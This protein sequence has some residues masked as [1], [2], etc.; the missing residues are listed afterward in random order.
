MSTQTSDAISATALEHRLRQQQ[1]VARFGQ[2]ALTD[3]P[4]RTLLDAAAQVVAEGLPADCSAV[5][6]RIAGRS[7]LRVAASVGWPEALVAHGIPD[8][9]GSQ[10]GH[11]IRYGTPILVPDAARE[12]RFEISPQAVELGV[13]SGI[14]VPIG[15]NG[16]TYGVLSAHA[17][18]P[19]EFSEHDLS[20]LEAVAN[21]VTSSLRRSR[22]E[23][24]ARKSLRILETVIDG[25]TDSVFVKDV[26][27]RFIAANDAA[28]SVLGLSREQVLSGALP[29]LLPAEAIETMRASDRVVLDRGVVETF[30]ET[31]RVGDD[32]RVFLTTKGPYRAAD[33]TLLGTFGIAR[34]ITAR[35]AVE[36]ELRAARDYADRLIETS[37]AIVLVLDRQANIRTFNRAAEE[38]T[39][40]ARDEVIGRNWEMFLPREAFPEPW[41]AFAELVESGFHERYE[42]L[43]V[44]KSGAHRMILWRNSQLLDGEGE[45]AGT[46]SF[47]VDVT[48]MV[49]ANARA[50]DLEARLRQAERLEALG[51]LA[52]GVAH[53]FNNLL[54]A[55]RGSAELALADP[56]SAGERLDE[57]VDVS[58]RAA[59]L[60]KQLLA[61]G[62]RQVL[63]PETVDLNDIVRSTTTMLRRLIGEHVELDVRLAD[64][65]VVVNA[66]RGQL[67][68]VITNL[69]VNA[70][71]AMPGGG[72]LTVSV[73]DGECPDAPRMRCALL[74]VSDA[75]VGIDEAVASRIFE[76]FFTTKG[77]AGTGLGLAT[78]Y[79]I[80]AQSGGRVVLE[81]SPG[82]GSTFTV[83]LPLL[84][85]ARVVLS[86]GPEPAAAQG[87][88]TILLV[89]DDP[90]VRMIVSKLLA[91]HGYDV[92]VAAGGDEA[93]VSFQQSDRPIPLVV[94]D[95]IMRG[96]D[97]RQ[98]VE[99]IRL[100]APGTKA[101]Y[102]SGYTDDAAIRRGELR[103]GTGFIQKPFSSDE[104]AAQV[105][106][107]LDVADG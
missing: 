15:S 83:H 57:I 71:D 75:G 55:I 25:T 47:G 22:A 30:E 76:P 91:S 16:D 23:E 89:E 19:R 44:T 62:R 99:Q 20:F 94:S 13:R 12:T 70:R 38:I 82:R 43:I 7:E 85:R 10:A 59:D 39:G 74:S 86:A 65:P 64:I 1:A 79:G 81:T 69:A 14:S 40:Y 90:A 98:T 68:Q 5:V 37:N 11:T 78:V 84:V 9:D 21:I 87:S 27:G 105:R 35:K 31:V 77:E 17:Y 104:L 42:N 101:L 50:A 107:L 2:L 54:L 26:E 49:A 29:Q 3:P 32:V 88:E 53:D 58:D 73:A 51:Q 60:T 80:V 56:A 46:V 34:D 6:E 106:R 93:L 24:E 36:Q 67:A 61:F 63:R 66:D 72:V 48:D 52:G 33:G 4:D 8:G 95:L 102:M 103:D 100:L 41:D 45:V 18:A 92:L 28:A 97:G 96:L